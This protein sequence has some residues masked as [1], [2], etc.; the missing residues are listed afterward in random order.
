[1]IARMVRIAALFLASVVALCVLGAVILAWLFDPNEYK[2]YLVEWVE[3]QTGREFAIEDDIALSFF[4]WLAVETGGV[5]LG[6]AP[7]FGPEPFAQIDRAAVRVV[8]G[9][10]TATCSS[11]SSSSVRSGG[12]STERSR[13]VCPAPTAVRRCRRPARRSCST[14]WRR[15]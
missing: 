3:Q 6:N 15:G 9:R 7:E 1:M 8:A 12:C 4:P 10:S 2:D 13:P 14:R 5:R 11:P